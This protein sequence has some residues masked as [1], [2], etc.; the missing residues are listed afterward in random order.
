MLPRSSLLVQRLPKLLPKLNLLPKLLQK[1]KESQ[2]MHFR[3][4]V[5]ADGFQNR[6]G[7]Y[8][9]SEK[10]GRAIQG[11][12]QRKKSRGLLCRREACA[13]IAL[14]GKEA[15]GSGFAEE[16]GARTALYR[17]YLL[18]K[19]PIQMDPL[20]NYE[21]GL[22]EGQVHRDL[23]PEQRVVRRSCCRRQVVRSH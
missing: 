18:S 15:R 21:S 1:R 17:K 16:V 7:A 9:V 4:Q 3:R 13:R 10:E 20:L 23:L 2:C 14:K 6:K 22:N 11:C 12:Q 5:R 8:L 19:L